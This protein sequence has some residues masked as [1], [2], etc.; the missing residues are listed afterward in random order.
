[1]N[2]IK[3]LSMLVIG[4]LV[5]NIA[6]TAFLFLGKKYKPKREGPR[7]EII[8]KLDFSPDQITAYDSFILEHRKAIKEADNRIMQLKNELYKNL[9]RNLNIDP[10]DSLIAEIGK[11]QIQIENIHYQHFESIKAICKPG[12]QMQKFELLTTEIAQL[13]NH[14]PKK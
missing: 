5:V 11:T 2:K 14:K 6:L 3:L 4:L 1:M 7:D 10:K 9:N 12:Q 13:F 8:E